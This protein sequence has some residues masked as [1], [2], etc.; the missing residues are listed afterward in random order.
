MDGY[1]RTFGEA[2]ALFV[3]RE[4]S[5][6]IDVPEPSE[7]SETIDEGEVTLD[8][9]VAPSAVVFLKGATEVFEKRVRA[10]VVLAVLL[11]LTVS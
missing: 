7:A 1:P 10:P 11:S 6:E 9:T 3:Q 8:V 4:E 5:D 2:R